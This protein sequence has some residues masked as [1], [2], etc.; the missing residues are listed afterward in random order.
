M[1]L[2]QVMAKER[3]LGRYSV[4]LKACSGSWDYGG[5]TSRDPPRCAVWHPEPNPPGHRHDECEC[6][7]HCR[8]GHEDP[9]DA[10]G[11]AIIDAQ[12]RLA[13][14]NSGTPHRLP[15]SALSAKIRMS[16]PFLLCPRPE[17]IRT[18]LAHRRMGGGDSRGRSGRITSAVRND[19][20]KVEAGHPDLAVR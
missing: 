5:Q 2:P 1:S 19:G 18:S 9:D 8:P 3:I 17:H 10:A 4:P 15:S 7:H 11:L 16:D 12:G 20:G 13:A 6:R 14:V